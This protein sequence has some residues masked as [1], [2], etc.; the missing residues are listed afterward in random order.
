MNLI[1]V[2]NQ[3][4]EMLIV[5]R[6][7]QGRNNMTRVRIEPTLCNQGRHKNDVFTLSTKSCKR[8]DRYEPQFE[9]ISLNLSRTLDMIWS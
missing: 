8:T 4:A 6:F 5:K 3:Q 2:R 9:N 1:F 7:I